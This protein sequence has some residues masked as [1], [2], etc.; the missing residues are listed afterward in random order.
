MKYVIEKNNDDGPAVAPAS[1]S[2]V[3][4]ATDEPVEFCG[5][6]STSAVAVFITGLIVTVLLAN[7][8]LITDPIAAPL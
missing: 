3:V 7:P 2:A 4:N 6:S 8:I 5:V 1:I